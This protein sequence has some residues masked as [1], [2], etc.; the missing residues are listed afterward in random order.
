MLPSFDRLALRP[1]VAVTGNGMDDDSDDM[2]DDMMP[3]SPLN[4]SDLP[5]E[6]WEIIL[7]AIKTAQPCDEIVK[8]CALNK[9]WAGMCRSGELYDLANRA[10][11]WYG[12]QETWSAVLALYAALKR[13]PP[14]DGTPKAYFQFACSTHFDAFNT[15]IAPWHPFYEAKL[16]AAARTSPPVL[17]MATVPW[18]VSNYE[19]VARS[20]IS[21]DH[22]Q[23]QGFNPEHPGLKQLVLDTFEHWGLHPRTVGL[24]EHGRGLA[25]MDTWYHGF[26]DH[27]LFEEVSTIL[28]RKYGWEA[29]RGLEGMRGIE[30]EFY[31]RLKEIAGERPEWAP[32]PSW[33]GGPVYN[34]AT[35]QWETQG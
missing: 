11:G 19:R 34:W 1:A 9:K 16:L 28:V 13:D 7:G 17:D 27:P 22:R 32:L 14:G 15:H 30:G 6:L 20:L 3:E 8:L 31:E 10:L 18:Y 4:V 21:R 29:L 12:K 2:D 5:P 35:G 23:L 25:A 26:H 24:P 33:L